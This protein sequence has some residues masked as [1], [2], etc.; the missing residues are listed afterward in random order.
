MHLRGLCATADGDAARLL[1]MLGGFFSAPAC[2]AVDALL[3]EKQFTSVGT[4]QI[5]VLCD[6]DGLMVNTKL[7]DTLLAERLPLLEKRGVLR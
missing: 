7:W 4:V 1:A 5:G 2:A 3:C 6:H